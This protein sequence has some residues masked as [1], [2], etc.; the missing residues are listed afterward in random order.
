MRLC[1][2]DWIIGHPRNPYATLP[3]ER[4]RT[5]S[6]LAP[7][8][9]PAPSK[10]KQQ[11]HLCIIM[12]LGLVGE[13]LANS[14]HHPYQPH[15]WIFC[16]MDG[17]VI[18][19]AETNAPSFVVNLNNIFYPQGVGQHVYWGTYW[20]PSSN[21]GKSYC[22]YPGY[23]FCGYWGC[24]TIVTSN[25]WALIKKDK[26][27]EVNYCPRGCETP[28]FN[29]DGMIKKKGSC[30]HLNV[31]VLQPQDK[32]L[33]FGKM[34]SVFLHKWGTDWSTVVQITRVFSQPYVAIGPKKALVQD[35]NK[36]KGAINPQVTSLV[37]PTSKSGI[38]SLLSTTLTY[39]R[40]TPKVTPYDLFHRMLK[41]IFLSL[42]ASEPNLTSS[43]WLCYDANPPFYEG[44]ALDSPFNYS[45][46]SSPQQCLRNTPRK[47][48]TL[49]QVS[50]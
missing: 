18:A 7:P 20:C 19:Q 33:S 47:G 39:L 6:N 23:L 2:Q 35:Q 32:S 41:A 48:I 12:F 26:V 8:E 42:N 3:E 1:L 50:S 37:N 29:S 17:S 31:T 5:P 10:S 15:T 14:D 24:E 46:G 38:L 34:W 43:C 45:S 9:K 22:N 40:N 49:E 16:N 11:W 13:G 30:I 28:T 25:R 36:N 27:L 4:E 44:V 21:P